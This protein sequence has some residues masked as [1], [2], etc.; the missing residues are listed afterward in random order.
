[1]GKQLLNLPASL[2]S[3][4]SNT[5]PFISSQT[6]FFLAYFFW[7][8]G[9]GDNPKFDILHQLRNWKFVL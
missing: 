3:A 7:G 8:V 5:P 4:L 2:F 6:N 9:V 1:M